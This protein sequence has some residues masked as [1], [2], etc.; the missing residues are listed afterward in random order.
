MSLLKLIYLRYQKDPEKM[1]PVF[2]TL[3]QYHITIKHHFPRLRLNFV[4]METSLMQE[5]SN[6]IVAS[7]LPERK[8][9]RAFSPVFLARTSLLALCHQYY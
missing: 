1:D 8:N 3:E 6:C 2:T 9:R 5:R 7:T 4:K